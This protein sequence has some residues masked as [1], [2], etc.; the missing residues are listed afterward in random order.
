MSITF[1][2]RCVEERF[3]PSR[4][5]DQV[6]LAEKQGFEFICI[7]D[8]FHP[9]FHAGGC[10]GHAWIW[11]GAA[12]ARTHRIRLG[13]GVTTCIYRYNPA[14]IAQAFATLGEMFPGRI[15]VGIGTGEAMNEVPPTGKP[16]PRYKERLARTMEGIQLMRALWE[17]DFIDFEGQYFQVTGAKLY[18]KSPM[19]IPIYFAASAPTSA[20]MA[21]RLGDAF[22]TG[23]GRLERAPMLFAAFEEGVKASGRLMEDL[24]KMVELKIA[25]DEDFDTALASLAIWRPPQQES[26]RRIDPLAIADPRELDALREGVDPHVMRSSVYTSMDALISMI[27]EC[28]DVG[29]TEIQVGSCSPDEEAFIAEFGRKALPY[30][31]EQYAST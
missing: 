19:K 28:V 20:R 22:M 2:Y 3:P 7:S 21:G 18:T 9:W 6:V 15:Y 25:Y 16:W 11:M 8:H 26:Q 12:G 1:G 23:G 30:L 27:E 24:P 10:A 29:F 31:Q 13:T 5:L 14:I 4:L 17:G